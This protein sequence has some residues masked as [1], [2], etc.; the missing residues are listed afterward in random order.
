[1]LM[2]IQDPMQEPRLFQMSVILTA[3]AGASWLAV[4]ML[5]DVGSFR[6]G[7]LKPQRPRFVLS[8]VA[9][10]GMVAISQVVLMSLPQLMSA[11][12]LQR[13]IIGVPYFGLRF[14]GL[15]MWGWTIGV[16]L[17]ALFST[18]SLC[19]FCFFNCCG[20]V[21]VVQKVTRRVRRRHTAPHM[22]PVVMA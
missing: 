20:R 2:P 3:I 12:R 17:F 15:D 22:P 13:I 8:M 7:L 9:L 14:F 10:G 4:E 1:M 5:N 18:L 6:H 19:L 21:R 16:G 11:E